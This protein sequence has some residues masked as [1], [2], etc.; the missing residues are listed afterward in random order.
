[1][2]QQFVTSLTNT[3]EQVTSP[4]TVQQAS[5]SL[6]KNF[7]SNPLVIPALIHILQSHPNQQIRQ[8]A[9]VEARKLITREWYETGSIPDESKAQIRASLLPSTLAEQDAL[10]RHTSSRVITAIA[11]YDIEEGEWSELL[12]ALHQAATSSVVAER[13]VSV[14]ILYTLLEAQLEPLEPLT[15][16]LLE[17]FS[18]TI[19]DPESLPVRVST[20]EA[21]GCIA[22]NF[23]TAT[24]PEGL[25]QSIE[26]FRRLV[27]TMIEVLKQVITARD[28]KS[29]NQVFNVISIL[30]N[31]ESNLLADHFGDIMHF[32][33]DNIISEKQLED[34]FRNPALQ[35]IL[36]AV[37]VKK[38]RVQALKLGPV[39]VNA[40]LQIA[41]DEYRETP[42]DLEDDDE[43]DVD[44]TPAKLALQLID[45]MSNNLAPSQVMVPLLEAVP[46]YANSADPADR[47]AGYLAFAYSI[48]GAP[49]FVNTQISIVLPAI[50]NGLN[51][52]D[53]SVK[54]SALKALYF[55]SVE[56][57]DIISSEH[58]VLLP[59]VFNIM[60]NATALKVGKH[61]CN[62]LDALLESM[63][64]KIISEKYLNSIA[65]K[66]LQLLKATT[67]LSLKSS[68]IAALSSAALASGENFTPYFNE[69]ITALEPFAGLVNSSE[70]LSDIEC[71][72]CSSAINALANLA[73]AV[74]K[75]TFHPY[76]EPLIEVSYKCLSSDNSRL[77]ECSLVFVGALAKIYGTDFNVFV[78]KIVEQIYKLLDQEEF[79]GLEEYI[80][81]EEGNIGESNDQD[82]MDKLQVSSGIVIE[83]EIATDTLG[84]LLEAAG[85]EFTDVEQVLGYLVNQVNHFSE[86]I[87]RATVNT[88]WRMYIA[89]AAVYGDK[90]V[91]AV[92]PA[93]EHSH[94]GLAV[95]ANQ[96]REATF[97]AFTT[98]TE[99]VV[100]ITIL[101]RL[102]EGLKAIGPQVILN[103][104]NLQMLYEQ[105]E[106]LLQKIHP[107]QVD[108]G[109]DGIDEIVESE[110][111]EY[112]EVLID[113][114]LDV[115]VQLSGK[116]GPQAFMPVF[117]K[118]LSPALKLASPNNQSN[119]ERIAS[120]GSLAEIVL[121]AKEN[122]TPFTDK[123][124]TNFLHR[125]SSDSDVEVRNN[126]VFGV[127]LLCYYSQDE[128]TISSSYPKI[129]E[130]L[131]PFIDNMSSNYRGFANAIGA[132]AR[133]A[134]KRPASVPLT[135]VVIPTL[136]GGALPLTEE[137]EEN[138]PVFELLYQ[139]VKSGESTVL[140]GCAKL[141]EIYA[142]VVAQE[143]AGK[144]V[145]KT[146]ADRVH[147]LETL[148]L[149]EAAQPG[150]VSSNEI[151]KTL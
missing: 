21:L 131:Q 123:L 133:M 8:L 135:D 97:D 72:V 18:K 69:T 120:I 116:I 64:R 113:S 109:D 40:A 43:E 27:P 90:D 138:G 46:K 9:G 39:L 33:I 121:G 130:K 127:G 80:E 29:A 7:Y 61:A 104:E 44:T 15:N 114:T 23:E 100:A 73:A 74:G 26:A 50:V 65:P 20:L 96:V 144:E 142:Q 118:L 102:A 115:I 147:V 124:L 11:S 86:G 17:L 67:N 129:L 1:M 91:P 49:D 85:V 78:P 41:A 101:D 126:A 141:T 25:E 59:L 110:S 2:D 31:S 77:K 76:V 54:V 119:S 79:G 87:R 137:F 111:S 112:D 82:F 42:D 13:E 37:R 12:P 34:E 52:S 122:I 103:L 30:L 47:R 140:A 150:L 63:D 146:P 125:I 148:K 99:R 36:T 92:L 22:N 66:L 24:E 35:F 10:V 70:E 88:L 5:E 94:Q 98:E 32:M 143:Q 128:S 105:L 38:L 93:P 58:E 106:L 16:N 68:I 57:R 53:I 107:A 83:K 134:L 117:E 149:I 3:L 75:T 81:E 95:I 4:A 136:L 45:E 55:L 108:E 139:L 56:L 60:D 48:E 6:Q 71:T 14:Y 51:D 145:F 62:A 28:E 151:L 19:A 132:V 89:W 84:D